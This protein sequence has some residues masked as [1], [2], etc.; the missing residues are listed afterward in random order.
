LLHYVEHGSPSYC[1]ER[2]IDR[3]TS[4]AEITS[5]TISEGAWCNIDRF[6]GLQS[7]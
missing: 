4:L 7:G 6:N 1:D 3:P 2:R 5:H